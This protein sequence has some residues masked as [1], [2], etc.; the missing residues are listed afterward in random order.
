MWSL[1][2][3]VAEL[4]TRRPLFPAIDENELLEFFQMLFGMPSKDMI[5]K[6][7]KR[8]KFFDKNGRIIRS[9]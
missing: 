3:I 6:C 5:E 8:T 9:R 4:K 2:C 7:R 1:G